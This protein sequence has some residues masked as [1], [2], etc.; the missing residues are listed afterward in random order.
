MSS[1]D[2]FFFLWFMNLL[3]NWFKKQNKFAIDFCLQ[4][5]YIILPFI[6][7]KLESLKKRIS[8]NFFF[9]LFIFKHIFDDSSLNE[10]WT[11]W[12][13]LLVNT[14]VNDHSSWI[15]GY[16]RKELRCPANTKLKVRDSSKHKPHNH[17]EEE[18]A[19]KNKKILVVL[20]V[21]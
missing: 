19:I 20:A 7:L 2:F 17:S 14:W 4:L 5:S 3:F 6:W 16:I 10:S 18:S 9:N 13:F 1:L 21:I 12:T 15:C 8:I 11:I